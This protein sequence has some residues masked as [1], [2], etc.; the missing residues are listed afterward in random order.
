MKEK[1]YNNKV[2]MCQLIIV[3]PIF[4]YGLY[5]SKVFKPLHKIIFYAAYLILIV[6]LLII[7]F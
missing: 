4:W 1:W 3:P 5:Y 6:V 2:L 7:I